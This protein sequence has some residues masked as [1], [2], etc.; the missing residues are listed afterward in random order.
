MREPWSVSVPARSFLEMATT[1][2]RYWRARRS[3]RVPPTSSIED[4]VN[5][6]Q[7]TADAALFAR[8]MNLPEAH[9]LADFLAIR[10]SSRFSVFSVKTQDVDDKVYFVAP[11]SSTWDRSALDGPPASTI[12][13][14]T[15]YPLEHP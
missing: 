6:S 10:T 14:V 7:L 5:R 3:L 8:G 2:E 11:A 9:A 13:T 15:T 1:E 4:H 12:H